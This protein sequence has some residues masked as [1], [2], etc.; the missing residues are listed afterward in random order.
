MPLPEPKEEAWFQLGNALAPVTAPTWLLKVVL[1]DWGCSGEHIVD[2]LQ[3]AQPE[4]AALAYPPSAPIRL[5][6]GIGQRLEGRRPSAWIIE[7]L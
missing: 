6:R 2:I 4:I 5:T 3:V 1:L 7:R